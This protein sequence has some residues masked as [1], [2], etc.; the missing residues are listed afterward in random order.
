MT[1][2][3]ARNIDRLLT[4]PNAVLVLEDGTRFTGYS[5][6]ATGKTFGELVFNTSLTGYQEVLTDPSYK[7]Q[8]VLMTYP[9]IG[10]YG[11]NDEDF[12]SGKIHVNGFAINRLSPIPSSWRAEKSLQEF[13]EK[14]GIVGIESVDTRALTMRIRDK[15]A[16]KAGILS[17][18]TTPDETA[19]EAFLQEVKAQPGLEE[20]GL[21]NVVST[22]KA[23]TLKSPGLKD[24]AL[25]LQRMTVIDYG[26]KQSIL[27][28]LQEYVEEV[29]VLPSTATLDDVLATKPQGVLLSN[30][31]GD[32]AVLT[33]EVKLARAIIESGLPTF[34]ICLGHQILGLACGAR[35]TKMP[36]GHHGGNHPVKDIEGDRIFIT[37]QNH[38]Y[39]AEFDSFP[40]DTLRVTHINLNDGTIEGFRHLNAP[41]MSVQ[42]HPEA[43]PGPHDANC[44]F[45]SFVRVILDHQSATTASPA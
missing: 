34:G 32:P 43:S 7:G 36:F 33:E 44:V 30:G 8:I 14:N 11:V 29:T 6:G 20:Q 21:T 22:P 38:G 31:P 39:A 25:S 4:P 3:A 16:M 45:K 12:E 23:Y 15:G 35:V 18:A 1:G 5:L 41:V 28:Y 40:E 27:R 2:P 17:A 42:F 10:N 13:L 26:A 19:I 24:P 37:S 9:E